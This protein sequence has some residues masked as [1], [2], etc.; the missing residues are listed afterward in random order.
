M[1]VADDRVF[2]RVPEFTAV[3]ITGVHEYLFFRYEHRG[4]GANN[5]CLSA[6]TLFRYA[7]EK[8]VGYTYSW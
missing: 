7:R 8:Q 4:A 2:Y 1:Y 6:G 5:R 3:W